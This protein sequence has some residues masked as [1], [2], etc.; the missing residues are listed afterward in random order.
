MVRTIWVTW[1]FV[2]F[3]SYPSAPPVVGYLS[4]MHRHTFNIRV[5]LDVAHEIDRELE[6]HMVRN[7]LMY[8]FFRQVNDQDTGS[9]EAMCDLLSHIVQLEYP[10]RSHTITIDEDGECGS[11]LCVPILQE[12]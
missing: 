10:G 12:P 2:G 3:H 7:K 11:T 1:G 6:F 5:E 9:C 8:A 4:H